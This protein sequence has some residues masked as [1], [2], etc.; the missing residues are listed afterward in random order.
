LGEF[1]VLAVIIFP[2]PFDPCDSVYHNFQI[3]L[4]FSGHVNLLSYFGPWLKTS[5]YDFHPILFL[6]VIFLFVLLTIYF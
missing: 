5:L 6:I 4:L 2:N 1:W 3:A